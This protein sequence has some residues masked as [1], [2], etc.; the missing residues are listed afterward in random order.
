MCRGSCVS[1]K[2]AVAVVFRVPNAHQ[3]RDT[4]CSPQVDCYYYYCY[5]YY[6]YY[7]YYYCYYYYCYYYDYH[8]YLYR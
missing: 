1:A 3:G 2:S 6:Y 4:G 7:Y 5:Y 8:Y